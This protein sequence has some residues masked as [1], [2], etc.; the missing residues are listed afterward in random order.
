M[1]K[2][3]TT[4]APIAIEFA[5]GPNDQGQKVKR[6]FGFMPPE[7]GG[8]VNVRGWT[9]TGASGTYSSPTTSVVQVL[10]INTVDHVIIPGTVTSSRG[11]VWSGTF[12][13]PPPGNYRVKAFG[14]TG[15]AGF[16]PAFDC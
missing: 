4:E 16:S 13:S 5:E 12:P 15:E 6:K 8:I 2:T 3:Q 14:N 11:G 1:E 9:C 10:L 7:P